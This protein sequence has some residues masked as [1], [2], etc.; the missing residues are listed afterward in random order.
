MCIVHIRTLIDTSKELE[1]LTPFFQ[2]F[3]PYWVY[4]EFLSTNKSSTETVHD[5]IVNYTL[6]MLKMYP[7]IE[8]V[9]M[10]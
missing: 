7:E 10:I 4:I 6:A 9:N 8:D 5:I 1:Q 2:G 3:D